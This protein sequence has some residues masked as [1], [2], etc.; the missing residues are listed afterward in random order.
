[1]ADS[2]DPKKNRWLVNAVAHRAWD[3][4][5]GQADYKKIAVRIE[6]I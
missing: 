5:S 1:V 4:V 2:A 3:P 6:R